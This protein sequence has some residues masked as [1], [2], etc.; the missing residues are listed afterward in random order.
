MSVLWES[1]ASSIFYFRDTDASIHTTIILSFQIKK[2][3]NILG[4]H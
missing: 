3:M 1:A 2:I 4:R